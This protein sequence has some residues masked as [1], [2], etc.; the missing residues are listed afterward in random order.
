MPRGC[1]TFVQIKVP[2]GGT[3]YSSLAAP[4]PEEINPLQTHELSDALVDGLRCGVLP[5]AIGT[6][7]ILPLYPAIFFLVRSTIR[8][9]FYCTF[10]D[11]QFHPP[12]NTQVV[13]TASFCTDYVSPPNPDTCTMSLGKMRGELVFR[14]LVFV[15]ERLVNQEEAPLLVLHHPRIRFHLLQSGDVRG[16]YRPRGAREAS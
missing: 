10:G 15:I 12:V 6:V 11:S 9:K 4:A 3:L 2:S 1:G 7:D 8:I 5:V 16:P 13:R 14:E